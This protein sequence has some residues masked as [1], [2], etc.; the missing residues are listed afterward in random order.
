MWK[1]SAVVFILATVAYAGWSQ[2][3]SGVLS[4]TER[5]FRKVC[6]ERNLPTAKISRETLD[7]LCDCSAKRIVT[8]LSIDEVKKIGSGTPDTVEGALAN[9]KFLNAQATCLIEIV[10]ERP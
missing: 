6:I 2:T 5:N 1:Y 8:E 9:L 3:D 10:G 4:A 7:K